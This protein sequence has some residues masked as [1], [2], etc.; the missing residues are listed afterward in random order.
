[1]PYGYVTKV[2]QILDFPLGPLGPLGANFKEAFRYKKV[3]FFYNRKEGS[4]QL[5]V[6]FHAA[7][8]RPKTPVPI[9]YRH[10]AEINN[11]S[12]L[13]LSD[14][15]LELYKSRKLLL[16]WFISVPKH[17]FLSIYIKII[18]AVIDH[19]NYKSVLFTGSSG[20]GY[21]ALIMAS[22]FKRTCYIANSQ[23]YL[24]NYHYF[25]E[26]LSAIK[27]SESEVD[28][29]INSFIE[30]H[31]PPKCVHIYCNINDTHHYQNHFIP[32]VKFFEEKFPSHIKPV[33]FYGEQP[34]PNLNHHKINVAPGTSAMGIITSILEQERAEINE[35]QEI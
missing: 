11:T 10:D 27:V 16:S 12:V 2:L 13:C 23:I 25:P 26:M 31:G 9:F 29:D 30:K 19:G 35:R 34:G 20:G 32:L 24:K 18:S 33:A 14:K 17:D 7:K 1:M 3:D 6:S 4:D 28:T 5:L 8:S 22:Y 21:P 15:L